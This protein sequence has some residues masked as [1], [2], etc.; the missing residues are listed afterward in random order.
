MCWGGKLSLPVRSRHRFVDG[1]SWSGKSAPRFL[2]ARGREVRC[3][4]PCP[5]WELEE[6]HGRNAAG[7][8][9]PAPGSVPFPCC[10]CELPACEEQPSCSL[11]DPILTQP[12]CSKSRARDGKM[13]EVSTSSSLWYFGAIHHPNPCQTAL[14]GS[15]GSV[16]C[17]D[18]VRQ[19]S[20]DLSL[21]ILRE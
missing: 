13:D 20:L 6:E 15:L 19:F 9:G 3:P 5:R 12:A 7:S 11:P 1:A 10:V 2:R 8:A 17:F 14:G 21:I 18:Q 4:P 16:L